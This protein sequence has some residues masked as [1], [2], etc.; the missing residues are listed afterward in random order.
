MKPIYRVDE[1]LRKLAGWRI[2]LR[3]CPGI[4]A[5]GDTSAVATILGV[6]NIRVQV[7]TGIDRQMT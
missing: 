3:Q 7:V 1:H 5:T 6:A 4:G 2:K